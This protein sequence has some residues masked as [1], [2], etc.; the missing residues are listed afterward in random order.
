[1]G[2][3]MKTG[4]AYSDRECDYSKGD[5][6]GGLRSIVDCDKASKQGSKRKGVS[7]SLFVAQTPQWFHS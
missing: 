6:T 5:E 2:L 3:N 4:F 7:Q 1:M